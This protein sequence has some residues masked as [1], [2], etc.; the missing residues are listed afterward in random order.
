MAD[1]IIPVLDDSEKQ[2][3]SLA[4]LRIMGD[5]FEALLK[6][7]VHHTTIVLSGLREAPD[8]APIML[9]DSTISRTATRL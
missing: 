9:R 7:P 6:P 2:P 8:W 5:Q 4:S 3:R 1:L